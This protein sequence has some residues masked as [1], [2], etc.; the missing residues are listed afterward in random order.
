MMKFDT[1]KGRIAAEIMA[2]LMACLFLLFSFDIPVFA[3]DTFL[4]GYMQSV[5]N[6]KSGIGSNEINCLYQSSS[7]YIWAGTDGGL[8]RTNGSG[9][10]SINLWDTDR[11]DLYTINCIT[12]DSKGRMWIGTDN[13][14]LFYI[15][16]GKTCHLQ[17]EY[18]NG[19]KTILAVVCSEDGTIYVAGMGG[20][21]V[22]MD[23]DTDA[24]T[25]S[26]AYC[27]K[28][29]GDNALTGV[30]FR[31]LVEKDDAIWGLT[32]NNEIY[33]FNKE[34]IL[35]RLE[36]SLDAGE[37]LNSMSLCQDA[38][39]VGSTGHEVYVYRSATSRRTLASGVESINGFMQDAEGRVWVCGDNGY[40]YFDRQSNFVKINDSQIDTYISDIIQDYEGNYWIASSRV[41]LLLLTKSKFSDYNL[42]SGMGE[43]MVNAVY[44]NRGKRYIATD[45]GLYIYNDKGEQQV[46]E[47]TDMLQNVS[48]RHII[49]DSKGNIWIS[50]YRKYGVIKYKPDGSYEV[51]G[52]SNGLP[53]ITVNCTLPLSEGRIAVATTEGM[54]ILGTDGRAEQTFG[55]DTELAEVNI[56]SLFETEEGDVFAG[57]DG[58]G[59]YVLE[60]GMDTL[61]HYG[62]E[63]GLNSDVIS[64]FA[65]GEQGVWIG[66]DSGVCF[67]NEAFRMISNVEYSN[68]VYDIKIN[69]G[70]VWLVGSMGILR[71]SEEELLGSNGISERYLSTGD[72][73]TKTINTTGNSCID[74]KGRLYICCNEGV[75]VLNT[76]NIWINETQPEIKVTKIDIDGVSYEF[77]DLSDGLVVKHDAS[78]ITIDFAVFSY[79][80]RGNIK[81][82]YKLEGFDSKETELHGDDVLQAVYTNLDGGVYTFTVNAYNADGTACKEPLSFVIDKEKRLF[83]NPIA[84][85]IVII[86][87]VII[88]LLLVFT[89]FH[90]R[91]M[92]KKKTSDL[93]QLSKE[94]EEAVKSSTAKNDYLAN[95]SN[96]I[97]TPI[98]AMM[99][100]ADELLHVVDRDSPYRKDIRGIYDIGNDIL[101]SVDDIILLA[102]LESGRIDTEVGNYAV[103]DLAADMSDYVIKQLAENDKSVKFFVELGDNIV[104]NLIGDADKIRSILLRLL[105]NAI[106]YTKQGSITLSIDSYEYADHGHQDMI[107]LVFTVA[108]TGIGIQEERLDTIFN[109]YEDSEGAKMSKHTGHGVGLAIAKGYADILHAELSVESVYGAG[110]TFVLS[111]NQKPAVKLSSGQVVTKIDDTVSKEDADKLWLPEV[112]ALLVDDDEV[113]I[114]VSRKV[115]TSFDMKLDV[116]TSGFSAIDMVLNHDYDVVFMDLSMPI[117]SGVDAM[118]E[119]RELDDI[120][121][122]MLPVIA[123]DPDAIEGNRSS[124]ITA[125]FTDSIVKPI[126]PRRVAAILKDCLPEEKLQERSDDVKLLIE[127]SRFRDGLLRLQESLDVEEAIAKIGGSIEVYNKL[128][129]AFYS[130]NRDIANTLA[131]K[132]VRDIRVFKSKIHSIRTLSNSIGA[133]ELARYAAKMEASINVGKR[134][135]LKQNLKGF[136]DELVYLLLILEDYEHFMEEVS[137]M[138]DEEYAAK[139]QKQKSDA[140]D[141]SDEDA[142]SDEEAANTESKD[143]T[144]ISITVLEE[145]VAG[146]SKG[147]YDDVHRKLDYLNGYGYDGDNQEFLHALSDVVADEN[148]DAITELVN[149]YKDLKL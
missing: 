11:T 72:G 117:M 119:I 7:G 103:S 9:F 96:E 29:Y 142:D 105:D 125:G 123:L 63:D 12:Q 114:E 60:H 98:H 135:Q 86:G 58:S 149:T 80:N 110:S 13:Y 39:Y 20:L 44:E 5:Y 100:K 134:E 47:L 34:K 8:Y 82:E 36:V 122:A 101:A 49:A 24:R 62:S 59:I 68:S 130:Q 124:N 85:T 108:D 53:A 75:S 71:S 78:K 107:N 26:S 10:Q 88:F 102:K 143:L 30:E 136:V 65:Q 33:I 31:S 43:C 93:E 76:E 38:V 27:L 74:T 52:R 115:L 95:M 94:H 97:K 90:V 14:G 21:Y 144:V 87:L 131:E 40:G 57:T 133:Y 145:I 104:D 17:E 37:E 77:D 19:I 120:K 28:A 109:L 147:D 22:I 18:Y 128:I 32:G 84:R 111:L 46:N 64:C 91:R 6:Q 4:A 132:S 69:K 15:E 45:D 92:L 61:T 118:R 41:G 89:V 116:A 23:A 148:V 121:Y 126:E 25:D 3:R 67:Y 141:V 1:K 112:S 35:R 138:T 113:S 51:F 140:D 2:F 48:V 70:S 66:T 83:E 16:D 127:G 81:A 54:A 42:S 56:L 99:V 106:R 50:T 139:M 137:G 55:M 129:H 73:L 146:A 79:S